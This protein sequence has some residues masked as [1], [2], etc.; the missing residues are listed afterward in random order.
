MATDTDRAELGM[1]AG[2]SVT[3]A[4]SASSSAQHPI[5]SASCATTCHASR[6]ATHIIVMIG[7]PYDL[8]AVETQLARRD[9]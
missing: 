7:H 2:S 3:T 6:S 1:L 4:S 8:A 9:A 5:G